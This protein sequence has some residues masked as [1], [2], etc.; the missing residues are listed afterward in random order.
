[1]S[2]TP[3]LTF[4]KATAADVPALDALV[5]SAYRGESSKQ[6]WTTE[7]DFIEGERIDEA[8]ILAKINQPGGAILVVSDAGAQPGDHPPLACCEV[9]RTPGPGGLAYFGLFAVN[10]RL[11][12]GGIGKRVLQEAE[13]YAREELGVR[14]MEMQVVWL[15]EELVAWYVRRGYVLF[16][17]K[18]PFPYEDIINGKPLR[19]DL[20]F[21]ILRKELV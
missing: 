7:A 3:A 5:R 13:R 1:M 18:R 16:D 20:Y 12:N 4:R 10:P 14:T 17:E 19:D 15:R 2:T 8:G 11:Q 6:G 9:S 21:V